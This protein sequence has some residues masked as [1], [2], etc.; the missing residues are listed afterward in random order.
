MRVGERCVTGV[1]VGERCASGV[2]VRGKKSG[3]N[4]EAGRPVVETG[5]GRSKHQSCP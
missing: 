4:R 5:G 2:Q 3:R 1:R